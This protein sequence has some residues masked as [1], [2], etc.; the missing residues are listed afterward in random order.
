[1]KHANAIRKSVRKQ[2]APIGNGIQFKKNL[3]HL[4]FRF[5]F[6]PFDGVQFSC[7]RRFDLR[8]IVQIHKCNIIIQWHQR[9]IESVKIIATDKFRSRQ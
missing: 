1:M 6:S 9:K 7:M 8:R 3:L 4:Y 2:T 5:N